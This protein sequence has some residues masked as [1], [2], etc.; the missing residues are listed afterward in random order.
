V[1]ERQIRENGARMVDSA[2]LTALLETKVERGE[3]GFVVAVCRD[4][5][6]LASAAV[7]LADIERNVALG[8]GS[9]FD[10]ASCSKQIC[11][12]TVLLLERD[13]VL[14][15]D[16]PLDRHLTGLRLRHPVTIRQCLQHTGG[17]RE[18]FSLSALVGAGPDSWKREGDVIRALRGQLDTDFAPDTDWS[19][20]NTGY[21][22][23]AAVVRAATGQSLADVARERV[24][25]PLGMTDTRFQEHA[26]ALVPDRAT[27]YVRAGDHYDRADSYDEVIGDGAVLTTAADLAKW[28]AFVGDG[29]VLGVEIRDRLITPATL[30]GNEQ[31]P[32]CLGIEHE[33]VF[34]RA[35]V[36]HGG[37]IEGYRAHVM[38]LLDGS[39]LGAV[40]LANRSD[41]AARSLLGD[42]LGAAL[43]EPARDTSPAGEPS[44]DEDLLGVW[45]DAAKD[46]LL[47]VERT[48]DGL[49]ANLGFASVS[50][51]DGRGGRWVVTDYGGQLALVLEGEELVLDVGG[52]QWRATRMRRLP[53]VVAE[54]APVGTYLSLELNALLTI[55]EE[56]GTI[57]WR[58]GAAEPAPLT[59][60]GPG[61]WRL[62]TGVVRV[63]PHGLAVSSSRMRR[64]RFEPYDGTAAPD[65]FP[66]GFPVPFGG[67]RVEELRPSA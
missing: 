45:L 13:G 54:P 23:V 33:D 16:D 29:R 30:D 8:A 47:S 42:V 49:V 48:D 51:A 28:L 37:A 27:G 5:V 57:T 10:I 62:P 41:A 14:R 44:P 34:G 38:Q 65:G 39:G 43:G 60:A 31:I 1:F 50:L 22:A 6:P 21:I 55:A 53:E 17:L 2:A 59:Q 35:A 52:H 63:D 61:L 19:Y 26:T 24:F 11:A 67:P 32:Y 25:E 15:I 4:G 3:P 9:V 12:T 40:V 66:L 56:S 18:Y 58:C 20:S 7:G 46:S 36:G 64:V